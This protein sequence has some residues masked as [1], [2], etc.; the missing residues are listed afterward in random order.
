MLKSAIAGVKASAPNEAMISADVI[1]MYEFIGPTMP[2][3]PMPA[4]S[5]LL[6]IGIK[7]VA[8]GPSIALEIIAGSHIV[9]FLIMLG[10]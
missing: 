6:Y 5:E 8:I 1:V 9:G 4:P 3:V 7:V 2:A 10:T